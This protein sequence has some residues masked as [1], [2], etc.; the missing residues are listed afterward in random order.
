M[1]IGRQISLRDV[2]AMIE[3]DRNHPSIIV[4]GVRINESVG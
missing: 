4:W 1:K 2:Q 3:R